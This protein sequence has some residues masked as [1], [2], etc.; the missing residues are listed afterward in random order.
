MS[1]RAKTAAIKRKLRRNL[2]GETDEK[3]AFYSGIVSCQ[4]L[5]PVTAEHWAAWFEEEEWPDVVGGEAD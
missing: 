5:E 3:P 1:R 4:G 2:E